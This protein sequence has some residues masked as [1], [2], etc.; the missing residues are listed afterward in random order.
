MAKKEP[1]RSTQVDSNQS[2]FAHDGVADPR[3]VE[4]LVIADRIANRLEGKGIWLAGNETVEELASLLE[5]VERFEV[6]VERRGGDLMVDEPVAGATTALEPD[7]PSF[8]LPARDPS[9][10]VTDYL[11]RLYD[12]TQRAASPVGAPKQS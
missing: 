11:K 8:V 2:N 1:K 7:D 9:E 3:D 6:V 12:A 4:R 10:S 5:A